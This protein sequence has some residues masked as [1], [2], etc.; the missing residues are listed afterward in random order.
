[1]KV[2]NDY[3]NNLEHCGLDGQSP[4]EFL[5]NYSKTNPPYVCT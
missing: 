2:W 4:N 3:Y 1:M 5:A